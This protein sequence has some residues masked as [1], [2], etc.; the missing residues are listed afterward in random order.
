MTIV[1]DAVG[2]PVQLD[3]LDADWLLAL[4]EDAD[5]QARTAERAKLRLAA[6]WCV[7]HEVDDTGSAAQWSQVGGHHKDVDERVGSAGTPLIAEFAVEPFAVA[8]RLSTAAGMDLLSDV[9]DLQHRLPRTWRRLEALEVP[10]WKCR[11]VAQATRALSSEAAAHVDAEVAPIVDTCGPVKL[12]RFVQQAAA[13]F[14]PVEQEAVEDAAKATWGARLDHHGSV[15]GPLGVWAGTST[16]TI[17]GDTPTLTHFHDLLSQTA[18]ELL[19]SEGVAPGDSPLGHRQVSALGILCARAEGRP[20]GT[21]SAARTTLYV[22]L[23]LADLL[24]DIRRVGLVERLG[25][26]SATAIRRWAGNP[27]CSVTPVLDMSRSDCVDQHDPPPWMADL[28]RLRDRTCVFPWCGRESRHCDLDHIEPYVALD[29]GG[30]PGQTSARN[31]APLCRRHH[32]L[33]TSRRWR[34]RR[35]ADGTYVWI[36]PQGRSYTVA[37]DGTV[38]AV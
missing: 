19:T 7:L 27:A 14:D 22:H 24:D 1:T 15:G 10:A 34:Y 36:S 3:E 17:T 18:H 4:A 38:T 37:P 12:D 20:A 30:P 2:M 13:R 29:D 35:D 32:R 8:L 5:L 6:Q 26:L 25:P 28:V 11:R 23:T 31:L 9:L 16:L 21:S 33:K